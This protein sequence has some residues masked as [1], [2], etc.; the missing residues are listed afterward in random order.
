MRDRRARAP[1]G[2]HLLL[3][4]HR[5]VAELVGGTRTRDGAP[6]HLVSRADALLRNMRL[7]TVFA[8]GSLLVALPLVA[9]GAKKALAEPSRSRQSRCRECCRRGRCPS[10]SRLPN[11]GKL[12]ALAFVPFAGWL[13]GLR[14]VGGPVSIASVS[15]GLFSMFSEV[16][17]LP[18]L[19]DLMRIPAD[20][21]PALRRPGRFHGSASASC[22]EGVHTLCARS[23]DRRSSHG[24]CFELQRAAAMLR[25]LLVTGALIHRRA[26]W[27][28]APSMSIGSAARL[29]AGRAFPER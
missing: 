23:S 21:L 17:A 9:E 5:A 2:L 14:D 18:F 7:V 25:Y 29:R 22:S 19:L 13:D 20:T 3:R 11:L 28:C 15:A 27:L 24:A 8:T 4:R 10:T 1:A 16:V 12:I 26:W 6:A